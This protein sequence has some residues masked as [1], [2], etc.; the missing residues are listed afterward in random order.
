MSA[1]SV[2]LGDLS[3]TTQT[4]QESKKAM[5]YSEYSFC[6]LWCKMPV[7]KPGVSLNVAPTSWLLLTFYMVFFQDFMFSNRSEAL[8]K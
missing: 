7:T 8:K 2:C 1:L 4:I 3:A 5:K 6:Y